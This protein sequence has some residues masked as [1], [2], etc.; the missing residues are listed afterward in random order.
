M[1][2]LICAC[3]CLLL[4]H[5]CFAQKHVYQ[6]RADTVRI[7]NTCDTAEL[8]LENRTKDT[9]GYL[10]NK[11]A[12]RTEFRR[13]H[14]QNLG[15]NQLAITGQDT[16]T[17]SYSSLGPA[18]LKDFYV[19]QPSTSR[20]VGSFEDI[21]SYNIPAGK[22]TRIGDKIWATYTGESLASFTET[23]SIAIVIGSTRISIELQISAT[24]T[25]SWKVDM[26]LMRTGAS[27]A[28]VVTVSN[29]AATVTGATQIID[30][31]N[32]NFTSSIPCTLQ[33]AGGAVPGGITGRMGNVR[34]E[35]AAGL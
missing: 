27:T 33:V 29:R 24:T 13:L 21:F 28:R 6:I 2:S 25:A 35:P 5:Y 7:Y 31:G 17:L 9:L 12:G 8:I 15:N 34:Y 1:K 26:L 4:T 30:L 10:F 20:S 19:N 11:G 23:K 16:V 32:L 22:L 14:L 3:A 18:P